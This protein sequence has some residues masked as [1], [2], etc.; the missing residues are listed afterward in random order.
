MT[1]GES[2]C[3]QKQPK[4]YQLMTDLKEKVTKGEI[5]P[6]DKLPSEMNCQRLTRSV[7]RRS[8]KRWQYLIVKAIFMPSMAGEH[9]AGKE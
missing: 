2:F 4:Y 3:G 1:K 7:V 8:G 6:G 5:R 9:F